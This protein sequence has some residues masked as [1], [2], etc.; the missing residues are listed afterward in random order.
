[1]VS[2]FPFR[3]SCRIYHLRLRLTVWRP[4]LLQGYP[5]VGLILFLFVKTDFC[6]RLPSDGTSRFNP[7]LQL[8]VP[9][10]PARSGLAP[11]R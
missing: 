5:S 9:V 8:A 3:Q 6:L 7:C 2:S 4:L 1:M 10:N 11:Y